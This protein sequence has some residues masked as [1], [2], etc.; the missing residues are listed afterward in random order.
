MAAWAKSRKRK[1]RRASIKVA[2][3]RPPRWRKGT[4]TL[5]ERIAAA[6]AGGAWRT[7]HDI[8]DASGISRDTLKVPLARMVAAGQVERRVNPAHRRLHVALEAPRFEYR[9]TETGEAVARAVG[10]LS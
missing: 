1:A 5:R 8:R 4:L 7:R 2:R 9:L 3:D 6:L 10:W